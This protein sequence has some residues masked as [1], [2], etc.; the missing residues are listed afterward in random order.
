M[1]KP[2]DIADDH[3]VTRYCSGSQHDRDM[4]LPTAFQLRRQGESY[5][6]VNW[7]EYFG[8]NTFDEA[9]A[10]IC[11][12]KRALGFNIRHTGRFAVLN[13]EFIRS[14]YRNSS[15]LPETVHSL[16]VAHLPEVGDESH[17]GIGG[18]GVDEAGLLVADLL[19]ESV[20]ADMLR[21][22]VTS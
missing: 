10:R 16:T 13:A 8:L 1:T 5:L 11:T 20:T 4:V 7:L 12:D 6:S 2:Q 21:A 14:V 17:S 19:A 3:H 22:P 9:L 15:D 18:Y